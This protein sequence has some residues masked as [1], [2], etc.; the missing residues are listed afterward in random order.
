M[1]AT[2]SRVAVTQRRNLCLTFIWSMIFVMVGVSL[3]MALSK[4]LIHRILEGQCLFGTYG[5]GSLVSTQSSMRVRM[6][7]DMRKKAAID[8]PTSSVSC[9]H[10]RLH[11]IAIQNQVRAELWRSCHSW[12]ES[13]SVV[14]KVA[15]L[16]LA[17]EWGGA[18]PASQSFRWCRVHIPAPLLWFMQQ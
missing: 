4:Y 1:F 18:L 3:F 2:V 11:V 16:A 10:R 7:P 6:R 13:L 5:C 8:I 12:S 14:S 15:M 17:T 9:N